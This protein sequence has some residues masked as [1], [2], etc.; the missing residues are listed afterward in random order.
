MS[1]SFQVHL[2]NEISSLN[3]KLNHFE[4]LAN[5]D[6]QE[7]R[8]YFLK[9]VNIVKCMLN[10]LHEVAGYLNSDNPNNVKPITNWPYNKN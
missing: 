8:E 10:G 9:Q 2:D 4:S 6:T 5:S 3:S 7:V 1:N